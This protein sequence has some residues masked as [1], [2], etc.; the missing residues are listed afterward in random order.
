MVLSTISMIYNPL[1]LVGP[2]VIVAK[3]FMQ[4]LWQTHIS[5]DG[6]IAAVLR[7]E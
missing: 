7:N 2:V 6:P 1:G 3:I 5:W 4:K